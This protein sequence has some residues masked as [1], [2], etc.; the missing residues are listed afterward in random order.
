MCLD[1]M[2]LMTSDKVGRAV[3]KNPMWEGESE[4]SSQ[5]QL[6]LDLEDR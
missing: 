5:G 1:T 2:Y 6:L 3:C 4:Q